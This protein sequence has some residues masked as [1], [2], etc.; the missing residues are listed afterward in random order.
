MISYDN[1][2]DVLEQLKSVC[3]DTGIFLDFIPPSV[4]YASSEPVPFAKSKKNISG[5]NYHNDPM[6]AAARVRFAEEY[7][8]EVASTSI[9]RSG[10]WSDETWKSVNRR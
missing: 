9:E 3:K 2:A 7:S 10:V 6:V 1:Y 5:L 8:G 4:I